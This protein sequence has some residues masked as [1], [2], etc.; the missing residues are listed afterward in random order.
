MP[1][2]APLTSLPPNTPGTYTP[3]TPTVLST[4]NTVNLWRL[5]PAAVVPNA[6][7]G[8]GPIGFS[9]LYSPISLVVKLVATNVCG[10]WDNTLNKLFSATVTSI[11]LVNKNIVL[12]TPNAPSGTSQTLTWANMDYTAMLPIA[13]LN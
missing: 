11:D 10:F 8:I 13:I 4:V 1:E 2:I 7:M 6:F 3:G 12:A 9:S 5:S